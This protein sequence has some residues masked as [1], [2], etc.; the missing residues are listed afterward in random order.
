MVKW[1]SVLLDRNEENAMLQETKKDENMQDI[2]DTTGRLKVYFMLRF[3]IYTN[4]G[5]SITTIVQW[6]TEKTTSKPQRWRAG[7]LHP[8]GGMCSLMPSMSPL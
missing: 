7:S 6:H 1:A 2:T 5:P 8:H 3:T 4:C